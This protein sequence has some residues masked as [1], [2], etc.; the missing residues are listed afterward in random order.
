MKVS[1]VVWLDVKLR[2]EP[3]SIGIVL[4]TKYGRFTMIS[5]SKYEHL[6]RKINR[7]YRNILCFRRGFRRSLPFYACFAI[8]AVPAIG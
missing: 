2:E 6:S 3:L 7:T 8:N 4:G 1:R 5:I